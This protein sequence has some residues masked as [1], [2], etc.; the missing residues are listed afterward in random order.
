MREQGVDFPDPDFSEQ[1]QGGGQGGPGGGSDDGE[2][3]QGGPFGDL[4]L[5]DPEIQAAMEECQDVFADSGVD[6]P[7]GGAA[8]GPPAGESP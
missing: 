5:D 6:V 4:D 2:G 7:G 1:P 8:G 3:A